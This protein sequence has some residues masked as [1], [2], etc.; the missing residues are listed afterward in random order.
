[1]EN[2]RLRELYEAKETSVAK[3]QPSADV[4]AQRYMK[5]NCLVKNSKDI[6]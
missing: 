5:H 3:L 6:P 4:Q 1:M 2:R